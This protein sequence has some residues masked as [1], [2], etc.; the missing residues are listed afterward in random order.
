MFGCEAWA[1]ILDEKQKA[2]QPKSEKCI[3]VGYYKD[4][5]G[6]ILFHPQLVG[7]LLYLTHSH[8]DLS[9]VVGH[10]S[11]YMQTPHESHWKVAKRIL[12]YIRG[13]IQFGI[14]YSTGG[15]LGW[16]VLLI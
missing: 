1:H 15:N 2:L 11:C 6:Y 13:T 12:R 3:F 14:H 9:F 8:R 16:L 10:V 7:S 5:K 4:V